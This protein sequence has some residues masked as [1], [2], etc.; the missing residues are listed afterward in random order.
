MAKLSDDTRILLVPA[1]GEGDDEKTTW[2]R[3]VAD[4]PD[5]TPEDLAAIRSALEN[6][7]AY[8]HNPGRGAPVVYIRRA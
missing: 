6:D 2:G 4:N 8:Q 7:N 5:M 3:F 1:T